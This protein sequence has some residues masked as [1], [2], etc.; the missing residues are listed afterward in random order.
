MKIWPFDGAGKA[1]NGNFISNAQLQQGLDPV[2]RIRA[3]VGDQMD[4]MIEGHGLWNLP[5]SVRIAKALEPYNV[6][7]LE[8]MLPQVRAVPRRAHPP[9]CAICVS[10]TT[11]NRIRTWSRS[12]SR[13]LRSPDWAGFFFGRANVGQQGLPAPAQETLATFWLSGPGPQ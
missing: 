9:L 10:A 4:I 11:S 8:E 12:R 5:T 7:W 13:N 2:R 3:A 1:N 6:A